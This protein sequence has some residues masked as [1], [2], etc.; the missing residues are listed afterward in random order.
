MLFVFIEL[1]KLIVVFVP[2]V[3]LFC[4]TAR[5]FD[6]LLG[7]MKLFTLSVKFLISLLLDLVLPVVLFVD[8]LGAVFDFTLLVT[9]P[10]VDIL[11]FWVDFLLVQSSL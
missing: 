2:E 8:F 9:V 3:L 10:S 1:L 6:K 5:V 7:R 4:S 11:L